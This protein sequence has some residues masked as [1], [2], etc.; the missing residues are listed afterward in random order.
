[1]LKVYGCSGTRSQRVLWALEELGAEYEYV[2]V[3]L[4]EGEGQRPAYLAV[5]PAGKVPALVDGDLV[6]TESAAICAY[7]GDRHPE[8]GLVPSPCTRERALYDRWCYFVISELEQPLW[9]LAKHSFALPEKLRVPAV[10]DAALWEFGRAVKV[11]AKGLGEREFL[12]GERFSAADI[13]AGH[14]LAW[15]S[16]A[17]VPVEA[18]NVAAYAERLLSRPALER[19]RAREQAG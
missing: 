2:T 3:N 7:L 17:E 15:A 19:A 9:T 6:L 14:T 16:R 12:V 8:A 10:R 5:N 1:M 13:L 4:L 11:L 18:P